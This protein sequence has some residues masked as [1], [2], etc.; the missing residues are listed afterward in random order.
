LLP[1]SIEVEVEITRESLEAFE[2]EHPEHRGKYT[3]R[4]GPAPTSAAE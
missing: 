2:N 1:A 3:N 4:Q